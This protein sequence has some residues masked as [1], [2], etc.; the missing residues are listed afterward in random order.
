M[1]LLSMSLETQLFYLWLALAGIFLF[2][3]IVT[4]PIGRIHGAVMNGDL[5]SVKRYIE[6]GVDVDYRQNNSVTPLCL[7][8]SGGHKE[9]AV[10][11]I[12]RGADIDRGLDEEHRVNP[13]LEAAIH[14]HSELVENFIARGAKIGIHFAALQGD[15]NAVRN[16]ID[17]EIPINATRNR[18]MTP[19]HC[20][21]LGG[22]RQ[23]AELL[24]DNGAD[25]NF[26]TPAS[27]TPL[28][29]AVRHNRIEV[30]ELLIDRGADMNRIGKAGTPLHVAV[31]ENNRQIVELLI[32]KGA[33]VN[34]Q[35]G[36]WD[37]ALHIAAIKGC[38]EIAELLLSSGAQVN[39][40]TKF[41]ERTPLHYAA[42]KG[43]LKVAELLIT[44]GANVN[45]RSWIGATPL[46]E[47]GN[48]TEMI[49]LLQSYGATDFGS[50]S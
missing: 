19:L 20:A 36:G 18:G 49:A 17:Q 10:F 48:C 35:N 6:N 32:A 39:S 26:D 24:I 22:H 11:L 12:E 4:H 40:S 44:Y 15:I 42:G 23:M 47:A 13:L 1:E 37:S 7:A 3:R 30:V 41:Q 31:Y 2:W 5:E 27:E 43:N 50:V 9:I 34:K 21:A 28:H 38:V 45:S 33:E 14:H 25:I 46:S 29:Q 8:A 16:Y